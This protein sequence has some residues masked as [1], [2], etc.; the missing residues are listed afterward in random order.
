MTPL[1]GFCDIQ[2]LEGHENGTFKAT[3][4]LEIRYC[5]G[6]EK[7]LTS[8][9][10]LNTPLFSSIFSLM[11]VIAWLRTE[12][13][14]VLSSVVVVITYRGGAIRLIYKR[15]EMIKDLNVSKNIVDEF[16]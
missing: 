11:T 15:G 5:L 6:K 1:H 14:S 16:A 8:I 3:R 12:R 10:T 7:V 13:P 4:I 9:C 2:K